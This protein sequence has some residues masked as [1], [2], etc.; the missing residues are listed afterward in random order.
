[1]ASLTSPKS[2]LSA[3]YLSLS[4]LTLDPDT[5]ETI[6]LFLRSFS[7]IYFLTPAV[8]KAPAGSDIE[9]TSS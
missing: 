4:K 6:F 8:A 9:R 7:K 1:M 3:I 2:A 5:I